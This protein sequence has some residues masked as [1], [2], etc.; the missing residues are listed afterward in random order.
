MAELISMSILAGAASAG[1]L[2]W[3][4]QR[5]HRREVWLPTRPMRMV[6]L[7]P[8]PPSESAEAARLRRHMALRVQLARLAR[9]KASKHSPGP[10]NEGFAETAILDEPRP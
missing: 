6:D 10:A 7:R 1:I 4:R 3:L 5:P 8:A 9:E 2:Y